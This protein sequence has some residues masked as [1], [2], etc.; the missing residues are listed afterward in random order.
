MTRFSDLIIYAA[1][2]SAMLWSA[3]RGQETLEPAITTTELG[4]LL[5]SESP[6][7]E[8]IIINI[9]K[10]KSATGTAFSI[11]EKGQWLSAR[12]VVDGCSNVGLKISK[13]KIL[14]VDT[15]ISQQ[16]DMALLSSDWTRPALPNDLSTERQI[17]ELGYF[18]GFPQGRPGEAV[19][20]LIGRNRM[21]VRGRYSSKEAVLAWAEIG[22]SSGI[23]GS[24]GGISGGPV[25]DK[26]GEI[27][28]IIT[29]ENPRRG[30]IYSVAPSQIQRFVTVET[31]PPEPL[32]L[33]AYGTI[34]DQLRRDRR[35]VQ[36]ICLVKDQ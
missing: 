16:A 11:N 7:D 29:A 23:L 26:D 34:A 35:I 36:V 3:N 22:R 21:V 31:L 15:T 9:G 28:G 5:P 32:K 17:G 25:L 14:R 27:I 19:G 4:P 30:R 10:A 13:N 2:I 1:I 18:F 12:H 8:Q 20:K 33:S 24:L 6:N